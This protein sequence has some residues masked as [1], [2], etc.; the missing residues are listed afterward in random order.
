MA[1]II[2]SDG[3]RATPENWQQRISELL[4][5]ANRQPREL[6]PGEKVTYYTPD[7]IIPCPN[8]LPWA[9]DQTKAGRISSPKTG[10]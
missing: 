1:Q 3:V 9:E 5:K 6:R 2:Y 10:K 4:A 8:G 7:P